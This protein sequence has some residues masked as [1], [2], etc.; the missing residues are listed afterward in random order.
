[1]ATTGRTT[2]PA[3]RETVENHLRPLLRG[4]ESWDTLLRKMAEQ[5]DPENT[6]ER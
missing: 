3:K 4:G 1:M 2:V 5:Y 6:N